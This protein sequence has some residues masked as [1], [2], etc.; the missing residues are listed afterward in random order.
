MLNENIQACLA[1]LTKNQKGIIKR[2]LTQGVLKQKFISMGFIPGAEVHMIRNAPLRDPIEIGIHSYL[3]TLRR[4]EA[5]L[6]EVD[7]L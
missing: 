5:S 4:T 2:C 1:D 7:L 3:I 6:I